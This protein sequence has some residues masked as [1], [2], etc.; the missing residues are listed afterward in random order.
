MVKEPTSGS[1]KSA[2]AKLKYA[3][4]TVHTYEFFGR[5]V[6]AAALAQAAK[7]GASG[8]RSAMTATVAWPRWGRGATFFHP[9]GGGG[10]ESGAGDAAAGT[11]EAGPAGELPAVS[12]TIC[13]GDDC[14][15]MS[16]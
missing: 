15:T 11:G 6:V 14:Y 8:K 3:A 2:A 1:Q 4:A 9:G 16:T 7:M 13:F 10:G 12:L 5:A